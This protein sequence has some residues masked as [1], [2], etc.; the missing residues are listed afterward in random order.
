MEIAGREINKESVAKLVKAAILIA[1]VAG[2]N[3]TPEQV[4]A[5]A[6]LGGGAVSVVYILEAI[7][8]SK[9]N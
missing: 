3:V 4:Q 5:I 2:Y 9:K 1:G 6:E 8:K 7:W